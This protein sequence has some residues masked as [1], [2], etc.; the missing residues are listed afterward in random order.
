MASIDSVKDP[1][2]IIDIDSEVRRYNL[3]SN[4]LGLIP[5]VGINNRFA[6]SPRSLKTGTKD[7]GLL[8][9]TMV[10]PFNMDPIAIYSSLRNYTQF[11]VKVV[12]NF[13][14]GV[15]ISSSTLSDDTGE[16]GN[17]ADFSVIF[18]KVPPIST[19][20]FMNGVRGVDAEDAVSAAFDYTQGKKDSA[21]L[22]APLWNT[23]TAPNSNTW[24]DT[25][26][27]ETNEYGVR[28][29]PVHFLETFRYGGSARETNGNFYYT[30]SD[31]VEH[32]LDATIDT[33][34]NWIHNPISAESSSINF[35]PLSSATT[36]HKVV[37]PC[38]GS[39]GIIDFKVSFN[40]SRDDG[41]L[42][43]RS[44]VDVDVDL[45]TKV[46]FTNLAPYPIELVIFC[47]PYNWYFSGPDYEG[48][49]F[50]HSRC[51]ND[52]L[53]TDSA[54]DLGKAEDWANARSP[55]NTFYDFGTG[56]KAYTENGGNMK[57]NIFELDAFETKTLI[58][59]DESDIFASDG[60]TSENIR[61]WDGFGYKY[62]SG[63][64]REVSNNPYNS[65]CYG[66]WIDLKECFFRLKRRQNA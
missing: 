3:A 31:F 47:H 13:P 40:V 52:F 66:F 62:T 59:I 51:R 33:V 39:D 18:A 38:P 9:K 25:T 63:N 57:Y 45:P 43:K 58:E 24:G 14:E 55:A 32:S 46:A 64:V 50:I 21:E 19:D 4:M 65:G 56:L 11:P 49:Y 17:V 26:L 29:G 8:D 42:V 6:F 22:W 36:V 48:R 16:Q 28:C 54:P 7:Y 2:F 1:N 60:F 41:Y 10:M 37:P 30:T 5:K 20:N 12:Y 15:D 44:T 53:M 35:P 34:F 61:G 27:G 23:H